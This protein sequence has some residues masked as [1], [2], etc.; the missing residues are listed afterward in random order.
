MS[1]L[2]FLTKWNEENEYKKPYSPTNEINDMEIEEHVSSDEPSSPVSITF[3]VEQLPF[4]DDDINEENFL[5]PRTSS[6]FHL[7]HKVNIITILFA[8][9]F[10]QLRNIQSSIKS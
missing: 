9:I 2:K 4:Q 5:P 10:F 1:K 7:M 6:L 8:K 3:D